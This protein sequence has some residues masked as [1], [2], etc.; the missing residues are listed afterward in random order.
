MI[1]KEMSG[2]ELILKLPPSV[3]SIAAHI[4]DASCH[5]MGLHHLLP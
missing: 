1:Q 2:V 4:E 3:F 5:Q